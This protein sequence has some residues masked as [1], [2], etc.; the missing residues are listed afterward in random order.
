MLDLER[1]E[2]IIED[3]NFL[4]S[5]LESFEIKKLDDLKDD[6]NFYSSSMVI[7]SILNRCVDLAEQIVEGKK[8]GFAM[9]YR[10]FFKMLEDKNILSKETSEEIQ[11][12]I[13]KRNKISH[14]YFSVTKEELFDVLNKLPVVRR[15]IQEVQESLK[16]Q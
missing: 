14:R 4:I 6:K 11:E 7:F 13:I 15:F 10:D 16:K 12:L 1:I 8:I 3:V 9:K 5:K 2:F